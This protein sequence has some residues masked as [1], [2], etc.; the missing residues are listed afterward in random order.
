MNPFYMSQQGNQDSQNY[1]KGDMSG[2]QG[3]AQNY[4]YPYGGK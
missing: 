4:Y 2:D 1:Y 3:Q